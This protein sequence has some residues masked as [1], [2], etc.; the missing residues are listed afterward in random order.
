MPT[1]TP[2]QEGPSEAVPAPTPTHPVA[3][4]PTDS[5]DPA[6]DWTPI[7]NA[8]RYHVQIAESESFDV[9]YFDDVA[10]RGASLSLPSLLPNNVMSAYWRVRAESEHGGLSPWSAP[11]HFRKPDAKRQGTRP[12]VHVDAAPVPLY[13]DGSRDRPVDPS[14]VEF[15][16]ESIPKSSGYQIQVSKNAD[17][18]DPIANVTVDRTT[19]V[20]LFNTLEDNGATFYWRVRLLFPFASAGPWSNSVQFSVSQSS[21]TDAPV[22]QETSETENYARARGPV[23]Q[24]HTS[25]GFSLTVSLFMVLTFVATVIS[26]V[27]M[28]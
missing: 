21:E 17:F 23:L 26:I 12:S 15:S 2:Y 3:G 6:F 4:R 27:V 8:D 9:L 10:E 11:A 5:P 7:P 13:P 24:S 18:G 1:P 28:S 14:A 22:E 20:V 25:R 16:W 19:S